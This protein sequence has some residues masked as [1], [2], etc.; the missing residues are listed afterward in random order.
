MS[1]SRGP[2]VVTFIG[3]PE[4]GKRMHL[5]NPPG[6]TYRVNI[7]RPLPA[8][9]PIEGTIPADTTA[10]DQFVYYVDCL[11]PGAGG[12]QNYIA[13]PD[14]WRRLPDESPWERCITALLRG[15]VGRGL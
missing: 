3:G 14:D 9:V 10:V 1:R 6:T 15:Y 8:Y 7:V 13:Y 4:D 2:A 12:N 5:R 11:P